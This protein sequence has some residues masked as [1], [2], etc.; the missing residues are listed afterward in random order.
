MIVIIGAGPAGLS[1]G[2]KLKELGVD[3]AIFEKGSRPG[4]LVRTEKFGTYQFDYGGH[5][6]HFRNPEIEK[7]VKNLLGENNLLRIKRR[8]FIFS[9]QVLTPYPFQV[10]TF[11]LPAQVIRDCLLGFIE[12]KSSPAKID[13]FQDWI[14]ANFGQGFARHFFFPF[15]QKFWRIP[16]TELDMEWAEWSVPR[17][18]IKD[19]LDG[20]LGLN[21]QDFGYNVHFYYPKKGGIE[22]L[23]KSLARG[24]EKIFLNRAIIA[25][26]LKNKKI[27]LDNG[28]EIGYNYLVSTMPVKELITKINDAPARIKK[29]GEGLRCISVLCVNLGIKGPHLYP[30]HW[31][32][33]PEDQFIF[34]RAG[35]YSNFSEKVS[36]EQ[37]VVLEVSYLAEQDPLNEEYIKRSLEDFKQTGLL[38]ESHIIEWSDAMRIPWAYVIFDQHRKKV[39]PG[40]LKFLEENRIY[41]I[42]RYGRWTYSTIEDALR[43][44]KETAE[45]LAR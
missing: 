39:L 1:C 24:L 20:A 33:F 23:V 7:W 44:G 32:Y 11:G 26:H 28:E 12:A 19:V 10:N 40:I 22:T 2:L 25:V 15:N 29:A 16:L 31:I 45:K 4:G 38:K 34:Y 17:P 43:Q 41:S 37:S 21:V 13:N 30:A 27:L 9:N 6:L 14:L 5:L 3:A 42:G 36:E 18:K 35:F 8:S